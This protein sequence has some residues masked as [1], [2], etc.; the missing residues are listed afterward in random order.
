MALI[1]VRAG[2]NAQ[3]SAPCGCASDSKENL[4]AAAISRV[5]FPGTRLSF[6]IY[7]MGSFGTALSALGRRLRRFIVPN[8][9][10]TTASDT[11]TPIFD[12]RPSIKLSRAETNQQD[13]AT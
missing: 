2:A 4:R 13:A 7:L 8:M 11:D 12:V 9:K 1:I 3:Y 5:L 6:N 10:N